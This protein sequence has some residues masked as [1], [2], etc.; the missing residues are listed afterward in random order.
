MQRD[1]RQICD[2]VTAWPVVLTPAQAQTQTLGQTCSFLLLLQTRAAVGWV[3]VRMDAHVLPAFFRVFICPT[4]TCC[5]VQLPPGS[6]HILRFSHACAEYTYTVNYIVHFHLFYISESSLCACFKWLCSSPNV[7]KQKAQS[8]HTW[9]QMTSKRVSDDVRVDFQWLTHCPEQHWSCLSSVIYCGQNWLLNPTHRTT[10]EQTPS[11]STSHKQTVS[12]VLL[13]E[14][15]GLLCVLAL[16][17]R[18]HFLLTVR[19]KRKG[20]HT[21]HVSC[22]RVQCELTYR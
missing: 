6:L 3:R 4:D 8:G 14:E 19:D 22:M 15:P 10:L 9:S 5:P 13:R 18:L 16:F 20:N 11:F 17:K 7:Q 2:P 1:T 21:N 12:H